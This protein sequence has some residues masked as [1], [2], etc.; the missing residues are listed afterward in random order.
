[1]HTL[2]ERQGPPPTIPFRP[3]EN[4]G[5]AILGAT[6]AFTIFA[7]LTVI[8]RLYVRIRMIRNVGWDD[9]VMVSTMVLCIAGQCIIIPEVY[10]GAGKHLEYIF[11]PTHISVALKLNFITQP[12]YLFAICLVKVS[13]GLFLLRIAVQPFYRK[14]IIGIMSFMSFYTIGCF[15]TIMFQCTD[16]RVQWDRTVNGTCWTTF[17]LKALSYTNQT[18]NIATDFAFS[19]GIPMPMLWGVQMN[20]RQKGSLIG[21]FGLGTFATVAAIVKLSY[22]TSYGRSGDWLWDS[23]N[24]TIWTVVE[25][26]V[27]IIAG[28][29]PALKPL[30][31]SALG[32]TY[33]R[34]SRKNTDANYYSKPYGQGS[35]HRSVSKNYASLTSDKTGNTSRVSSGRSSP[36]PGKTSSESITRLNDKSGFSNM[37][38]I[39]VTTKVDVNSVHSQERDIYDEGKRHVRAQTKELV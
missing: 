37:G 35:S 31:R 34:G 19:I 22:I 18:L 12:L 28:S 6:L 24:L 29:L 16:L 27:A 2:I 36:N 8:A 11:P 25:C 20:R 7:L 30:F 26:N 38:G 9:Y 15:F 3:N 21:I 1:M 4:Q 17:T 39:A 14:L 5:P 10:Y 32:S 23:R 33:G 13:V